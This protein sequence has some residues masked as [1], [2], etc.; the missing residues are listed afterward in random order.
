MF[1]KAGGPS[2]SFWAV[3]WWGPDSL[4]DRNFRKAILGH[5]D[6]KQLRFAV[7][8]ETTGRFG[9]FDKPNYGNW[10]SDLD[11]LN[12]HYFGHP[13][14]LPISDR[15]VLFVYLSREYFRGQGQAE[16]ENA[17][18]RNGG[19][20]IIGDDVF[21]GDYRSEWAHQFDAVTAY[22]VYGQSV[23]IK[24]TTRNAVALLADNYRRAREAS[25]A[26]GTAFI[27]AVAPGYNDTVIRDGHP[28]M[29][30]YFVN[31]EM[32]NEGDVFR[33]MIQ[34][35]ALPNLD[36]R[37]GRLMM[38]TS[39]NE[40]YE[41]SQIEATSGAAPPTR[42]DTSAAQAGIYCRSSVRRLLIS[43]FGHSEKSGSPTLK[44]Q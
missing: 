18:R 22:D 6:A 25:N 31:D 43:L 16:M 9:D 11:Y 27:P 42:N 4:T 3:S 26:V 7:L 2:I 20:Y 17:H 40:W 15:P 12:E 39:F 28:A 14:Y 23:A 30:R 1:R 5:P 44:V 8:Y 24:G 21:G 41:D 10:E 32:S 38:V 19:L 29:P 37:C 36:R 35:A 34:G 13:C 33:A